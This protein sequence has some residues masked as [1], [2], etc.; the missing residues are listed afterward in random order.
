MFVETYNKRMHI[1]EAFED[2]VQNLRQERAD[3]NHPI[4]ESDKSQQSSDDIITY[5]DQRQNQT[6]AGQFQSRSKGSIS[7]GSFQIRFSPKPL[8]I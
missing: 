7:G 4:N 2:S 8:K 5:Q 1:S 6:K 3:S